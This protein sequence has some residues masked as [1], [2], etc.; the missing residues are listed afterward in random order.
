MFYLIDKLGQ[1]WN[2]RSE[3]SPN[4][5]KK[6]QLRKK[7]SKYPPELT[8]TIDFRDRKIQKSPFEYND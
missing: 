8:E 4:A 3:I 5:F 6:L 2:Q 1:Y 7:F